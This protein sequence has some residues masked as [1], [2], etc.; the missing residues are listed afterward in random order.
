MNE[1]VGM[2]D[3]GFWKATAERAVRSFAGAFLSV[4]GGAV[5]SVWDLDWAQVLGVSLA[6]ALTSVL[7]SLAPAGPTGSPSWVVDQA[8]GRHSK[9]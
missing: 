9:G 5:M 3:V 6:A 2:W 7:F 1:L 8:A 4:G